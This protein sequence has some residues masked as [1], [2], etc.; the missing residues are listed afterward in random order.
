MLKS[1]RF[2]I[3]QN[4][5]FISRCDKEEIVHLSTSLLQNL[6]RERDPAVI[7]GVEKSA[8]VVNV[9]ANV[10]L[11]EW[12]RSFS[13]VSFDFSREIGDYTDEGKHFR[14]Q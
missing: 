11:R 13:L 4:F 8:N 14:Q 10:A 2:S 7:F 12:E 9:N 1:P 3:E 5:I 6:W